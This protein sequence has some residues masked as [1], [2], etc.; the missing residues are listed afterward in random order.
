MSDRKATHIAIVFARKHIIYVGVS[1]TF[2][3]NH[4]EQTVTLCCLEDKIGI[5]E[6]T[7][8]VQDVVPNNNPDIVNECD[9]V[10]LLTVDI[11]EMLND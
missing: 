1:D 10:I 4:R 3:N 7:M 8:C 2:A 9:Y 11:E 5:P 6:N